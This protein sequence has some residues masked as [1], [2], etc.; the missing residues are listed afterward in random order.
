MK[1]NKIFYLAGKDINKTL[2]SYLKTDWIIK[3]VTPEHV[4]T[5]SSFNIMGSF[6]IVI[7]KDNKI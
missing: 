7:E 2:D 4:A 3:S 5:G 6:V 1:E